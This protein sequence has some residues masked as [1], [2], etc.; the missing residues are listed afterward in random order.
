MIRSLSNAIDL[1]LHVNYVFIVSGHIIDNSLNIK[2]P[3]MRMILFT[4]MTS[5]NNLV[6]IMTLTINR[7]HYIVMNYSKLKLRTKWT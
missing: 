5:S 7:K 3:N 2:K 6:P 4:P 1:Q